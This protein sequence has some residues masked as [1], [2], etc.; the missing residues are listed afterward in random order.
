MSRVSWCNDIIF[1]GEYIR[2]QDSPQAE[3]ISRMSSVFQS[4]VARRVYE[5]LRVRK[6]KQTVVVA[7]L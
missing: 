1:V 2:G 5:L 7:T 3:M 6:T 4:S